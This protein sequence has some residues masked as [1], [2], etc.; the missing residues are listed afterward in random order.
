MDGC[1]WMQDV[2]LKQKEK[3]MDEMQKAWARK[4]RDWDAERK[5][6]AEREQ[7]VRTMPRQFQAT[8]IGSSRSVFQHGT[9]YGAE[10]AAWR[11]GRVR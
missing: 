6:W 11:R 5:E 9:V 2:L 4:E 1:N 10:L 7:Q 3:E 8:S